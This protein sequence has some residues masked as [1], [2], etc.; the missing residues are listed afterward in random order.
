MNIR[1]L[2]EAVL[3]ARNIGHIL[4]ATADAKGLPHMAAAGRV[5]LASDEESVVVEDWFCPGTMANLQANRN[6][7]LIIWD[8][9]MDKGYQLLGET[10]KVE[11]TAMMN[12]YVPNLED[13]TP[14]PQVERRVLIRVNKVMAFRKLPHTDQEE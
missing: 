6:T 2:K 8:P 5:N 3:L 4:I 9:K 14:L 11:D 13:K 1:T 10:E 7:A 12:G